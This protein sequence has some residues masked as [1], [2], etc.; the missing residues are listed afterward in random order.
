MNLLT[1]VR[2][3]RALL[4]GMI[5]KKSGV[6]I[7]ISSVAGK[8]PLWEINMAYAASKAAL[9]SYSKA[10]ANEVA[11]KGCASAHGIPG[12]R[13]DRTNDPVDGTLRRIFR[14]YPK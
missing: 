11:S 6:I 9:N 2:L 5:E 8:M 3:D 7:H 13:R 14:R 10:L 1:T 4:P 12:R